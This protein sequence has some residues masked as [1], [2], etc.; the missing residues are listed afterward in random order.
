[1]F[2]KIIKM[3]KPL[4]TQE[5]KKKKK[6]QI[7]KIR[8]ENGEIT[9]AVETVIRDGYEQVYGNT[10]DNLDEMHKFLE[11]Y[12]LSKLNEKELE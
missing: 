3:D 6:T 9:A 2:E 1:M 5:K 7:N 12:N 11:K 10:M 4:T 8:N